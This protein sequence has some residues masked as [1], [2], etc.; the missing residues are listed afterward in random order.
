MP[1]VEFVSECGHEWE[2]IIPFSK[3]DNAKAK[4]PNC[5]ETVK[6]KEF[7]VPAVPLAFYGNP[8]GYHRPSATKRHSYKVVSAKT[9]NRDSGA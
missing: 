8:E 6:R 4:C 3:S 7:S 5:G 2:E 9:G 1:I